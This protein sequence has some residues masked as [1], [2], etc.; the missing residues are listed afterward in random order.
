MP[1]LGCYHPPGPRGVIESRGCD[2]ID[3]GGHGDFLSSAS[4]QTADQI[5]QLNDLGQRIVGANVS[6][7]M[8]PPEARLNDLR[9]ITLQK[10]ENVKVI[11]F[12]KVYKVKGK[13][14]NAHP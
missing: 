11:Q 3:D 1:A 6:L 2:G 4:E 10:E 9:F 12:P 8:Q 7:T 5:L 13:I 14:S